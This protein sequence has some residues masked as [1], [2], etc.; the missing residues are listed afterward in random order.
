M[1]DKVRINAPGAPTNPPHTARE[2]TGISDYHPA[3]SAPLPEPTDHD[4]HPS[5]EGQPYAGDP[6]P[7]AVGPRDPEGGR[8]RAQRNSAPPRY[9]DIRPNPDIHTG[10]PARK[11]DNAD[12]GPKYSPG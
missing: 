12:H 5:D 11:P 10:S 4:P 6:N 9:L 3:A 7:R 1:T 2:G 8:D